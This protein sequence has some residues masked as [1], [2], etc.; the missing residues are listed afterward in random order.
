[1]E[2]RPSAR[3]SANKAM[4]KNKVIVILIV[5]LVTVFYAVIISLYLVGYRIYRFPT[6]NMQPTIQKNERIIGRLSQDYRDG[7]NRFDIVIYRTIGPR[8]TIHAKRVIGLPGERIL[9]EGKSVSI[10]GKSL[11]MPAAVNIDGLGLKPCDLRIPDDSVFVLG[12]FTSA[13]RDS[14]FHGPVPKRDVLGYVIFKK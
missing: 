3:R 13:S 9:I 7:I 8:D 14:R 12:D 6:S 4:K 1:M 5:G 2:P 11:D 10:D